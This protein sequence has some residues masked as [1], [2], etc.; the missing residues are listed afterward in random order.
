MSQFIY[1][2]HYQPGFKMGQGDDLSRHS[3][4]EI[5]GMSVYLFNAEQQMDL[6]NN[7]TREEED[8]EDMEVEWIDVC[9]CEKKNGLWIVSY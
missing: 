6:E 3:G 5:L 1:N 2:I 9:T 4:E 8:A 7:N